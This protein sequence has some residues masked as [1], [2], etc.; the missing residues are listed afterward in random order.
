VLR[1]QIV[2]GTVN[3]DGQA[4]ESAIR[5]LGVFETRWPGVVRQLL[6]GR[7]PMEA[8]E[9]LLHGESRGIKNVI[10]L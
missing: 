3:A 2:F 6:T 8:H 10:A 5:D 1:N 4:F 7:Y 9:E